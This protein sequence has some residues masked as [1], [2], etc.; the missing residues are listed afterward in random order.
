[1]KRILSLLLMISML[2]VGCSP[3]APTEN[4][5]ES[6]Q[7]TVT[8][9]DH[10]NKEVT[11]PKNIERVVVADLNPMPALLSLF[12][13]DE[14]VIVGMND[15][16]LDAAQNGIIGELFP[17]LLEVDTSF[18]KSSE[19]NVEQLLK[20]DP[21]VVFITAGNAK[22]R[23]MIENAGIPVVAFGVGNWNY[24][25]IETYENWI[26]LLCDLFP[27][28][29]N[30][31]EV[32]EYSKEMMELVQSKVSQLS[33]DE[34]KKV[35]FMFQYDEKRIVTSGNKF[36]GEYW[37]QS[38]GAENVATALDAAS[39]PVTMEQIYDWQPDTIFV[40]NFTNAQPE[41]L[42]NNTIGANDWSL[43]KAVKNKEVYK[44]PLGSFRS[45][46]VSADMPITLLWMAQKTYPEL[47]EDINITDE[48][49]KFYKTAYNVELTAEQAE[50]MFNIGE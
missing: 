41:D 50:Q 36:F 17:G 1:M 32:T 31:V 44:M 28:N 27:A 5:I 24:D 14:S 3:S 43:V 2:L 42:Y 6:N 4:K 35:F 39:A 40:T 48:I 45:Y 37:S 30:L 19:L 12:L 25:I 18:Y 20:L 21:Q 22:L 7:E 23:D 49:I 9:T 13:Q 11:L 15:I 33:E 34:I 38:V 29:N 46:S 26:K 10:D 16:S 8:I 47:F